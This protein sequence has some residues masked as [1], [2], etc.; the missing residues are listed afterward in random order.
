[1]CQTSRA[2]I[3][4]APGRPVLLSL[5][6]FRTSAFGMQGK[7]AVC[8]VRRRKAVIFPAHSALKLSDVAYGGG[9]N[10]KFSANLESGA[11]EDSHRRSNIL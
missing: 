6:N 9:K 4:T 3:R 5:G 2:E 11:E 10:G 1:M 8:P 7:N